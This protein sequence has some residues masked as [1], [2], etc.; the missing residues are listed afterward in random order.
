MECQYCKNFLS[1]K[2]AMNT[3]QKTAK[4]CIKLQG[5]GEVKGDF[6]CKLCNKNFLNNNRYKYHTGI[7]NANKVYIEEI[8]E[9]KLYI[10]EL[11]KENEI[12]RTDKKDLQ[13]SYEKLSL[14]AVS[15]NFEDET[16]I[17]IDD[18]LSD[19]QF[20][21]DE[22]DNEEDEENT[23]QLTPLEVGSGYIIEHR[24]EDRYINVTNLCKAG[25]KQFKHWNSIDKTKAFLRV[26]S[27][28]VGIPTD[29]LIKY[30]TAYGKERAT[31]VQPHVA[32][33]IA[34]WISPRFDVKVSGWVY[35]IM[36]TGKVD[37]TNTKTYKELQ[38]ENKNKE[39]KNNLE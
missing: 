39:L 2:S 14:T 19:S 1:S 8:E 18:T 34:Q 28:S 21:I 20:T 26:L 9:M 23:Y 37:I 12:L 27:E 31:R 7:C 6:T 3:H 10:C 29:S 22:S 16:T 25:G 32:I 38:L 4:Y 15:R 36:M 11:E 35:E 30:N 17:D 24:D 33:N 5:K 13:E